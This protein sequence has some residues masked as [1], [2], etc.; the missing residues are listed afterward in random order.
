MVNGSSTVGKRPIRGLWR[1]N[2]AVVGLRDRR[3]NYF[4]TELI[5]RMSGNHGEPDKNTATDLQAI[6]Q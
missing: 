6:D 5:Q 1:P 2:L 4:K 3:H